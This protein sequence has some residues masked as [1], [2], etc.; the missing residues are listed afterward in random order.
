MLQGL[1][2][3]QGLAAG[4]ALQNGAING[5]YPAL[6]AVVGECIDCSALPSSRSVA[7]PDRNACKLQ[8][9][10]GS[11]RTDAMNLGSRNTSETDD[12]PRRQ[13]R[14]GQPISCRGS[15]AIAIHLLIEG[16]GIDVGRRS[17]CEAG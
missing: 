13:G 2:R 1:H 5:T 11:A 7:L 10:K 8:V 12:D 14:G 6:V 15:E 16:L 4:L 17:T 3:A 9:G